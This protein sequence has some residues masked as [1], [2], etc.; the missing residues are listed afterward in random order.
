MNKPS[1]RFPEGFEMHATA[2]LNLVHGKR[3]PASMHPLKAQL[4]RL[5]S[6]V[7]DDS[8]MLGLLNKRMKPAPFGDETPASDQR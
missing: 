8:T 4:N 3:I 1:P 5:T 7:V 6:R 2:L